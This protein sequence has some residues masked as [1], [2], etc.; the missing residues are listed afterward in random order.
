MPCQRYPKW[1]SGKELIGISS[2]RIWISLP[3]LYWL[4]GLMHQPMIRLPGGREYWR[5]SPKQGNC[6]NRALLLS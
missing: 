1:E 6:S 3:L 5:V 2:I 4:D